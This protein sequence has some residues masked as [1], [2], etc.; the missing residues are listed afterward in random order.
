MTVLFHE[1]LVLQ[2]SKQYGKQRGNVF[3]VCTTHGSCLCIGGHVM[4]T[5]HAR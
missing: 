3:G 1:P 5:L 4:L 2:C